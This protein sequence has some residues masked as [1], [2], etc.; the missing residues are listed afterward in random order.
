M[1]G[2]T[3]MIGIGGIIDMEGGMIG[4]MNDGI[5]ILMTEGTVT[6]MIEGI[7]TGGNG[8]TGEIGMG[9]IGH[10]SEIVKTEGIEIGMTDARDLLTTKRS[11]FTMTPRRQFPRKRQMRIK[12]LGPQ[13]LNAK[14]EIENINAD[15]SVQMV[16]MKDVTATTM[17]PTTKATDDEAVMKMTENE[18][19][20]VVET[21]ATTTDTTI[22]V[23]VMTMTVVPPA[24]ITTP[25][26]TVTKNPT[27][28]SNHPKTTILPVIPVIVIV[29]HGVLP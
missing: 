10:G 7:E 16:D 28:P 26:T 4:G 11:E 24:E 12:P 29:A 1:I 25:R 6:E 17:I 3:G 14:T 23:T 9:R 2:G 19:T 18:T 15:E 27:N 20:T 8:M 22:V 21:D 5:G 13:I